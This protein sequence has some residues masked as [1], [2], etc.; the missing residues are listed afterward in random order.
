MYRRLVQAL[1]SLIQQ[2]E[3]GLQ[4]SQE[5]KRGQRSTLEPELSM[6]QFCIRV[7]VLDVGACR[8]VKELTTLGYRPRMTSFP[9][10][11]RR[12][13]GGELKSFFAGSSAIA[14]V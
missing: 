1:A 14:G 12:D 13:V 11:R 2:V 9:D 6:S 10:M 3:L 8:G 5:R 4:R 7:A